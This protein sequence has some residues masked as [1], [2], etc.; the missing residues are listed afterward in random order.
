M[1]SILDG[2]DVELGFGL[3][4]GA[5][6]VLNETPLFQTNFFPDFTQV[7]LIFVTVF[8]EFNFAQVVPAIDAEFAG[9]SDTTNI[10][11]MKLATRG[12]LV[13]NIRRG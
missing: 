6:V 11:L 5:G 1:I 8:V 13:R 12:H 2:V 3:G 10:A 4:E 9:K 7:Y